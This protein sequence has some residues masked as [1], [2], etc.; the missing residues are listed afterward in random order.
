MSGNVVGFPF[1]EPRGAYAPRSRSRAFAHRRN[2]DFS[3]AQTHVRQEWRAS[4]RRASGTAP[5]TT[6]AYTCTRGRRRSVGSLR[7]MGHRHC[8][9]ATLIHGGLTPAAPARCDA[10]GCWRN[11]DFCDA[12]TH[13]HKSGGREPAVVREPHR[14]PR[15]RTRAVAGAAS[16]VFGAIGAVPLRMGFRKPRGLTPRSCFRAEMCA[17]T[18]SAF[19]LSNHGGLRPRLLFARVHPPAELRL[20]RCTNARSQERRASACRAS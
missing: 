18:S 4:A 17:V 16:A 9:R 7:R 3:D 10:H 13:V 6:I 11:C 20:F 2:C 1:V 12:R 15:L 19:R 8:Q 5:A 14:Q